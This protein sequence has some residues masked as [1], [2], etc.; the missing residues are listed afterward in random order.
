MSLSNPSEATTLQVITNWYQ[1]G[2]NTSFIRLLAFTTFM[3]IWPWVFFGVVKG[4]GGVAMPLTVA[5]IANRHPQDVSFFVTSLSNLLT[6]VVGYLSSAAVS[7]LSR[8]YV[9]H[10]NPNIAHISFLA[11]LKNRTFPKSLLDQRRVR[12]VLTVVLYMVV[13][14]FVTSGISALLTPVIF[15]RK[16]Q[17]HGSELDFGATDP[18]CVEWFNNNTIPNSCD[19]TVSL[20]SKFTT[21]KTDLC[22]CSYI[23]VQGCKLYGLPRRKSAGRCAGSCPWQCSYLFTYSPGLF[24]DPPSDRFYRFPRTLSA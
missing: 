8:K 5:S 15:N 6:F 22:F 11:H 7:R 17:L 9:V 10:K 20:M 14:N 2:H 23:G 3:T 21:I 19:W 18:A 4:L 12:P 16:A 24:S 1:K 13:F